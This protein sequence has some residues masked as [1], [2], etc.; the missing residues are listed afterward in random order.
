MAAAT[1]GARRLG[2]AGWQRAWERGLASFLEF[3]R[4]FRKNRLA[5]AGGVVVLLVIAMGV[6]A[7]W[8]APHDPTEANFFRRFRPPVW[9]EG[10]S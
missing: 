4:R 3:W 10:G 1:P 8:I 6:F 7:P 9:M 2:A 5:V